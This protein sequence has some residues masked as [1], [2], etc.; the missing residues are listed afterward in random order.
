[1]K[2]VKNSKNKANNYTKK[3][4]RKINNDSINLENFYRTL[5]KNNSALTN[6]FINISKSSI[7][8]RFLEYIYILLNNKQQLLR[9]IN[10]VG[11]R[12]LEINKYIIK[13]KIIGY[14]EAHFREN[15]YIDESIVKYI[16]TN[17]DNCK[18]VSYENIINSKK[19][20]FEFIIYGREISIKNLDSI[21]EKML[22]IV[23]VIIALS[24][25]KS[26]Q[27]QH[28][29]IFLTPFKKKL[30]IN[31]SNI[32]GAKN[33]NSGFT[34][35]NHT[36]NAII[37]YRKE[38]FFKVFIHESIHYYGVDKA[39]HKPLNDPT[40]YNK[41]IKLFNINNNDF[42]S[43][44][45]N[46]SIT[47]FWAFIMFLCI[48]SYDRSIKL[49]NFIAE[50]ERLYKIELVHIIFQLVKIL[51]HNNL[52]YTQLL[53]K[54]NSKYRETTHIFSYYIIKTMLVY[55]Y[56]DLLGS[57]IF[58]INL[59]KLSNK[60]NICIKDDKISINNLLINL[61][62]Y[63]S[64]AKFIKHINYIYKIFKKIQNERAQNKITTLSKD[65]LNYL[66]TNLQMMSYDYNISKR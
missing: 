2:T 51:N 53:S 5:L 62:K 35:T 65:K 28:V 41:F 16:I 63:A 64:H 33:A 17:I 54:T 59:S 21:V 9:D 48:I 44:G 20:V 38:E 56:V 14:A 19:Y 50:Y 12:R 27:G 7:M 34:Y 3:N 1:M 40:H 10:I 42:I 55:N 24:N 15:K 49:A 11:S 25:N 8:T 43:I 37:I 45:F 47:E 18:L 36:D 61:L 6:E 60:I 31:S 26:R 32:L 46:E 23:Q 29:T 52:T 58:D 66:L 13:N 22:L 4:T 57:N 30:D 39:L